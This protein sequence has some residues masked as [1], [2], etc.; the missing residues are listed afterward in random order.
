MW[1]KEETL[2]VDAFLFRVASSHGGEHEDDLW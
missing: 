1:D 2:I